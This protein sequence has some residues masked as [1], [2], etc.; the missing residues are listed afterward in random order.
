VLLAVPA[1]AFAAAALA[2]E[3]IVGGLEPPRPDYPD[4]ARYIRESTSHGQRIFVW[5]AFAPLYVLSDR[6][7]ASRFVAFMRGCLPEP[8]VPLRDCWDSGRETWPLLERDLLENQPELI[9]DTAPA[10]Y[11]HFGAY[12][13]RS[14]PILARILSTH[15]HLERT[16]GG[17]DI[18]RGDAS[19][20]PG[21]PSSGAR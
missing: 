17:V 10:D 5:G 4:V 19:W 12:A 14:V 3:P 20:N 2:T 21:V 1:A 11:R 8:A 15:Y 16:I 6:P 13:L 7:P 18:Y 9:V